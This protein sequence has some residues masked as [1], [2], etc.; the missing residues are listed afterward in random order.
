MITHDLAEKK[1]TEINLMDL[2]KIYDPRLNR[3][4][5]HYINLRKVYQEL[6]TNNYFIHMPDIN[7][8]IIT[9]IIG[10]I[11]SIEDDIKEIFN[12]T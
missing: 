7:D 4:I 8:Y 3:N 2:G 11:K 12:E 5:V 6:V 10:E 1:P 9:S